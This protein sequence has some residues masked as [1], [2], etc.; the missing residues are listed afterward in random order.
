MKTRLSDS[1]RRL[2]KP[3][4]NIYARQ[5]CLLVAL[6]QSQLLKSVVKVGSC[7]VSDL[8]TSLN[9]AKKCTV[10]FFPPFIYMATRP[11]LYGLTEKICYNLKSDFRFIF[12]PL[13]KNYSKLIIMTTL[14]AAFLPCLSFHYTNRESIVKAM[15]KESSTMILSPYLNTSSILYITLT[16]LPQW[17]TF[18]L[19]DSAGCALPGNN[20]LTMTRVYYFSQ[21]VASFDRHNGRFTRI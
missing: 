17:F 15:R 8:T 6:Q 3:D 1:M 4:A 20:K 7:S 21:K 12:C 9:L 14:S 11:Y 2:H 19:A 10:T 16:T 18:I 5:E 13:N